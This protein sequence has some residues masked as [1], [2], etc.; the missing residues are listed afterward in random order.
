MYQEG[1][2][3]KNA[4]MVFRKPLQSIEPMVA[5]YH[6]PDSNS[7]MTQPE[8][9]FVDLF[10]EFGQF[11]KH[12][13]WYQFPFDDF[14]RLTERIYRENREFALRSGV[15]DQKAFKDYDGM[16]KG[17]TM[18]VKILFKS[19]G[20]VA[21]QIKKSLKHEH[22]HGKTYFGLNI[23][24]DKRAELPPEFLAELRE[25]GNDL[26]LGQSERYLPFN[27]RMR[28]LAAQGLSPIDVAGH[29]TITV[30]LSSGSATL[31]PIPGVDAT[32]MHSYQFPTATHQLATGLSR[33]H[34]HVI[35]IPVS[36]TA[37]LINNAGAAGVRIQRFHDY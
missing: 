31:A 9:F 13:P 20:F 15:I 21:N 35:Q 1:D 2:P 22:V 19:M 25:V 24:A 26:F 12:T 11:M 23:P 34:Y 7:V 30:V 37:A 16:D 6:R 36:Q 8:W 17:L 32:L 5:E 18:A 29:K 27:D 14:I 33:A 10:E 28:E 3:T 4:L